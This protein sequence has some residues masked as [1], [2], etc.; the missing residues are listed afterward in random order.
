MFGQKLERSEKFEIIYDGPSFGDGTIIVSSLYKQ[1]Q[2]LE[3]LIDD[4]VSILVKENKLTSDFRDY[5]I[6]IKV[7]EGSLKETFQ[8]VFNKG[9]AKKAAPTLIVGLII[10][11]Y[12]HFLSGGQSKAEEY[13]KNEI[14][15]I[16]SN[17]RYK[18][19]LVNA[20]SP[21]SNN[22]DSVVIHNGDVNINITLDN[23]QELEA[24]F[25]TED[26]AAKNGEFKESL[27][28]SIRKLDLDASGSNYF[29][30]NISGGQSRIP[31]SINGEFNLNDYRDII[32]AHIKIDAN[33]KYKN[34]KI[35]HI[36]ILSYEVI[37]AQ[38]GLGFE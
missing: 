9:T 8:V 13:Y 32:D 23:K 12:T 10:A 19:N 35:V 27:E 3:Q 34:G 11:T 25:N 14:S 17:D 36:E 29:G 1:L 21:L 4:S 15:Q 6:L 18:S 31:T 22:N 28:G 26:E 2:T 5:E 33:V 20:L 30:F 16:E 24:L 38:T 7:E 37:S